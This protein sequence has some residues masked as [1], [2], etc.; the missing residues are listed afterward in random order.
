M[1]LVFRPRNAG[2]MHERAVNVDGALNVRD[3]GGLSTV[4]GRRVRTGRVLRADTLSRLTDAGVATLVHDLGVRTIIDLRRPEEIDIEGRGPAADHVDYINVTVKATGVVKLDVAPDS[5]DVD[6]ATIYAAYLEHSSHSVVEVMKRLSD[7]ANLPAVV[8]CTVGKD[9][10][11]IIVAVL[12]DALGVERS[13]IIGDYAETARNMDAVLDRLRSTEF[14]RQ[15]GL[16]KLPRAIFSAEPE[17][18]RRVLDSL[19]AEHGGGAGWLAAHGFGEQSLS[20]LQAT[21]LER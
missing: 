4:D 15:V 7:P 13:Q 17:T 5:A 10:T 18:M 1:A 3:L 12:L 8:H 9:R 19:T 16:D 11:G 6:L 21:L 14:Y 2:L 20:R